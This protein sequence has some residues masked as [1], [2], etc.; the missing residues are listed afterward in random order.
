[1]CLSLYCKVLF[2]PN[3]PMSCHV[4]MLVLTTWPVSQLSMSSEAQADLLYLFIYLFVY[5]F[6]NAQLG[7][8][9]SKT[10]YGAYEWEF[11]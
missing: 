5:A 6:S 3:V 4:P 8:Q 10:K 1:M 11:G 7:M 9:E 2:S